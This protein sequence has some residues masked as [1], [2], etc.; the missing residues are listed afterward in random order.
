[1]CVETFLACNM[2]LIL[3][4]V[5]FILMKFQSLYFLCVR[6]NVLLM[7][8]ANTAFHTFFCIGLDISLYMDQTSPHFYL[9]P[10]RFTRQVFLVDQ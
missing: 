4:D 5:C 8:Q 9:F 10:Y 1:M 3:I 2:P 7:L 6:F